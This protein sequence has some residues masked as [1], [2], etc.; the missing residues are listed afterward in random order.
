MSSLLSKVPSNNEI[1]HAIS[2]YYGK[3]VMIQELSLNSTKMSS[4]SEN[5]IHKENMKARVK[6]SEL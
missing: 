2:S 4:S 6:Q 1:A 5:S 3:F